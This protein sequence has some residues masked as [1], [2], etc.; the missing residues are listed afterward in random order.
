M[1]AYAAQKRKSREHAE[2]QI[3]ME[4]DLINAVKENNITEVEKLLKAGTSPDAA[5]LNRKLYYESKNYLTPLH[6]AAGIGA[7]DIL[8]LGGWRER[9][10]LIFPNY[11]YCHFLLASEKKKKLKK[12]PGGGKLTPNV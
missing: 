3:K 8:A 5:E 4:E 9:K 1:M 2:M 12:Q 10:Q 7:A 6:H 11:I